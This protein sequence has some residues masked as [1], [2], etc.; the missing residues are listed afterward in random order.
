MCVDTTALR[1][2]ATHLEGGEP[3]RWWY[4]CWRHHCAH[5]C[6]W[7]PWCAHWCELR[8]AESP[9]PPR[10]IDWR[11]ERTAST[12]APAPPPQIRQSYT[13]GEQQ[14]VATSQAVRIWAPSPCRHFK[15]QSCFCICF[16]GCPNPPQVVSVSSVGDKQSPHH[17]P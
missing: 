2:T 6:G 1:I 10:W 16:R 14:S 3:C 12:T 5:Y 7:W 8:W 13:G 9:A 11:V 15:N 4:W 17:K